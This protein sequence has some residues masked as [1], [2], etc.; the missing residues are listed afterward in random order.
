V[1]QPS[2]N[3]P[4]SRGRQTGSAASPAAI[5]KI[6]AAERLEAEVKKSWINKHMDWIKRQVRF[7]QAGIAGYVPEYRVQ[8]S[9]TNLDIAATRLMLNL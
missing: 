8:T 9:E 5:A 1:H 2:A 7:D 6:P 4:R 3:W